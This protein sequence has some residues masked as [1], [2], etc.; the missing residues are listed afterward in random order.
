MGIGRQ[1]DRNFGVDNFQN[2]FQLVCLFVLICLLEIPSCNQKQQQTQILVGFFPEFW[3]FWD[4]YEMQ[5]KNK[6]VSRAFDLKNM[7]EYWNLLDQCWHIHSAEQK[8]K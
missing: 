8:K 6:T 5:V 4:N 2:L 7:L 3:A 1:E